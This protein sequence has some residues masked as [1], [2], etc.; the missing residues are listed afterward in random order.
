[1]PLILGYFETVPK[2]IRITA[3]MHM[4]GYDVYEAE[5]ELPDPEWPEHSIDDLVQVAF[6]GKI[7][8]DLEHPVVQSLLGR[9]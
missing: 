9:I 4:S 1:L 3:N 5:G 6:R 2:W 8:P 7:I